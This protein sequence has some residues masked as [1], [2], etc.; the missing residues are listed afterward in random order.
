MP[1]LGDYLGA[2]LAEV[3]NARL[4]ADL[5]TARIAQLYASHPLLQHMPV[6]R[7]RLPTVT[8]DL[9]VAVES[10]GQTPTTLPTAQILALRQKV[11]GIITNALSQRGAHVTPTRQKL[12][13]QGIN[14]LFDTLQTSSS[15]AASDATK[16]ASDTVRLVVEAVKMSSADRATVDPA[17]ESSLRQQLDLEFIQLQP[18]SPRVQVLVSAAQLKD[19]APPH[20]L[21]RI[22]LTITE[23]GV[24]WSQTNPSDAA[25]K[26][27]LPE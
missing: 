10:L 13:T 19:I 17:I 2:L 14:D 3:T 27:L 11:D 12:L 7:F 25:S 5:E 9:P 22:Q 4:L 23:E 8:L 16:A 18:P 6:P 24:E 26:T 15:P 21:T 1:G 20:A